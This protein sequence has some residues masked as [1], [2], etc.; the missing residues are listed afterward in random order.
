MQ[1]LSLILT[2]A[3]LIAAILAAITWGIDK[4]MR[5]A[6]LSGLIFMMLREA[7]RKEHPDWWVIALRG[8]HRND[9]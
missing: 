4:A 1:T 8:I 7:C 2:W 9:N 3:V 6:G 5:L